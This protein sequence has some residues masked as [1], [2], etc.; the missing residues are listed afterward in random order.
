MI[1]EC[2][3]VSMEETSK[4]N[5]EHSVII[6]GDPAKTLRIMSRHIIGSLI[7]KKSE[8]FD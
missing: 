6:S 1:R 3:G 2:T 5:D 8:Y 7:P 4:R